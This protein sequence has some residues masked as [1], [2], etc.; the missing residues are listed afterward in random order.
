MNDPAPA[1]LR[2]SVIV[3][4][5]ND[6][7]HLCQLVSAL[8]MLD[9]F[10]EVI[11]VD[12]SPKPVASETVRAAGGMYLRASAPNRGAQMNLGTENARGDFLMF[13]HTDSTLAAEHLAAIRLALRDPM[14]IG[15]ASTANSTD[16][17]RVCAV[18][19]SGG[20]RSAGCLLDSAASASRIMAHLG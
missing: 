20:A 15:G 10:H 4:F 2:L 11:M 6:C 16:A 7:D 14:V 18:R 12:A 3:P 1:S 19:E 5:W 9:E 13:H 17:I 8:V